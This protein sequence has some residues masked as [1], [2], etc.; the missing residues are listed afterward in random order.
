MKKVISLANPKGGTGKTT[1]TLLLADVLSS[2][3]KTVTIIDCDPNENLYNWSEDRRKKGLPKAP[4]NVV[5]RPDDDDLIEAIEQQ[6][7]DFVI[8]DLEG[9]A[10]QTVTYALSRSDLVLVPMEPNNVE[11]RHAGRAISLINRTARMLKRQVPYAILFSK[12]SSAIVTKEETEIRAQ[13]RNQN[14]SV[15]GVGIMRR[16]A[17]TSIFGQTLLLSELM[18]EA[19]DNKDK[20]RQEQI[21]KAI[22]NVAEFG[23]AVIALLKKQSQSQAA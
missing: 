1:G 19:R 21:E 9:T 14:L 20:K 8:V 18:T 22:K 4:F 12:V 23:Q 15:L 11:A 13:I 5:Q 16:A 2:T 10:S 3:G 17:Y 7:A 6:R